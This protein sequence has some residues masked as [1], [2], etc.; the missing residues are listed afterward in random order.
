M[1]AGTVSLGGAQS[2]DDAARDLLAA[3]PTIV[4][5]WWRSFHDQDPIA[6]SPDL[7]HAANF[8]YMLSGHSPSDERVRG[9]ETY[10]NTVVDHGLNAS[11]F[12]ARVIASTEL[13]SRIGHH[14]RDRRAQGAAPR[15]RSR[16]GARHGVRDRRR[17]RAEE[18]LRRKIE[19]GE[20]LMGFGHRVYKVR[21]PRADVLAA[22][23][24]RMFTRGGSICVTLRSTISPSPSSASPCGCSRSTNRAASCRRTSSSTPRCSCTVSVWKFRC[25]RRPSPSAAWPAG[26]PTA[27]SSDGRTASSAR[28]RST[29][30]AA[31]RGGYRSRNEVR[32]LPCR[33][34]RIIVTEALTMF[35]LV[36][37]FGLAMFAV[38]TFVAVALIAVVAKVVLLPL[39]LMLIPFKLLALPFI[40]IAL[41]VKF[42]FLVSARLDRRGAADSAGDPGAPRGGTGRD[43]QRALV[44]GRGGFL[45]RQLLL[46]ICHER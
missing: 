32:N 40:A 11:T 6:P 34:A 3:F 28:N 38:V 17:R 30:A 36:M 2:D 45:L 31:T 8:L 14:R 42:A 39:R 21:D 26:S 44:I 7:G 35:A 1:A 23:A 37:L 4:A 43:H 18:V 19:S 20:K 10:L 22:A 12:A 13:R 33:C 46:W 9:L 27:S 16:A 5:A 41:L 29:A 15:R 25:S 24:E